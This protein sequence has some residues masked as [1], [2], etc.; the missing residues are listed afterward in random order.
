MTVSAY[1]QHTVNSPPRN[2]ILTTVVNIVRLIEVGDVS[3]LKE[4]IFP[5]SYVC[6]KWR[7]LIGNFL[8]TPVAS[9]HKKTR[10]CRSAILR[11]VSTAGVVQRYIRWG[12]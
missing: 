11:T 4:L 3:D 10:H 7:Y 2:A 6:I 1:C 8:Y 5:S 9:N 12:S